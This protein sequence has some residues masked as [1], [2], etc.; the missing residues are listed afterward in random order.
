MFISIPTQ[1]DTN[2]VFSYGTSGGNNNN[3]TSASVPAGA[4][5][6]VLMID[7]SG[8]GTHLTSF[9]DS[10]GNSYSLVFGTQ[11]PLRDIYSYDVDVLGGPAG[12]TNQQ[13]R[14]Q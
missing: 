10:A 13:K 11:G 1:L 2:D 6:F 9:T 14:R 8:S 12:G 4:A 5:I 7:E 3:T